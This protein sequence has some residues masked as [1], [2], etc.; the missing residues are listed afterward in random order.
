MLGPVDMLHLYVA[1]RV[2]TCNIIFKLQNRRWRRYLYSPIG[3]RLGLE[4]INYPTKEELE[5]SGAQGFIG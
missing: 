2:N 5:T 1:I 4:A 3:W